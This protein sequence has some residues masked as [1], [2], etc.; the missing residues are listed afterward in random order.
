MNKRIFFIVLMMLLASGP[1]TSQASVHGSAH[2]LVSME[3]FP[4]IAYQ[5]ADALEY[6]LTADLSRVLPIMFSSFVDLS[7]LQSTSVLGRMLGEQIGS[8]FSQ[9]GYNVV[10]MRL[11]KDSLLVSPGKGELA[12]SRSMDHIRDSWNAQAVIAGTYHI[13]EDR[14]VVSARIVSTLD[15]S[16]LS[17]HDFSFRLNRS[18]MSMVSPDKVKEPEEQEEESGLE[19]AGPLSTGSIMLNP[20]RSTDARLIQ[21]RLAELGLYLDKIDGIWGKNS[22]I[23]LERYKA[24]HQLPQPGK[25]D[26]PTQISL[27]RG[28]GQ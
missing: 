7:D 6:N 12:L 10:D 3:E 22:K 27:F 23:A 14:A 11:R 5:A 20:S 15:N 13:V 19:P 4:G 9:H 1:L 21:S 17:S 18:L 26:M 25:W 8:R 28:T 24:R 2:G 16:V